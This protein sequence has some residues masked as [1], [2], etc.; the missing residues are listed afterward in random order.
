M[1]IIGLSMNAI[2]LAEMIDALVLIH[3]TVE[4]AI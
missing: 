2:P 4:A 1:S 3:K